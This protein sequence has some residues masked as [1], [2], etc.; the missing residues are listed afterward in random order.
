MH[1]RHRGAWATG[2]TAGARL[3]CGECYRSV[4]AE[5][6]NRSGEGKTFELEQLQDNGRQRATTLAAPPG[7]CCS[8]ASRPVGR[9]LRDSAT[10]CLSPKATCWAS[11]LFY[12]SL[13]ERFPHEPSSQ[14]GINSLC[15]SPLVVWLPRDRV[16]ARRAGVTVT[17]CWELLLTLLP[18][19]RKVRGAKS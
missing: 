5:S 3:A 16:V 19:E 1:S 9:T 4:P 2:P 12:G 10:V 11:V 13:L 7:H 18:A 17:I 6:S 14:W 8:P 15:L